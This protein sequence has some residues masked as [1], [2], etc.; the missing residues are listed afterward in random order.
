MKA[1]EAFEEGRRTPLVEEAVALADALK[2]RLAVLL[3]L[4]ADPPRVVEDT[5]VTTLPPRVAHL[6]GDLEGEVQRL[7]RVCAQVREGEARWRRFAEAAVEGVVLH[8]RQ[9]VLDVNPQFAELFGY[10]EE[11]ALGRPLLAFV[12]ERSR[13]KVQ[14]V[15]ASGS[16]DPYEI[17]LVRKDGTIVR[18]V[19]RARVLRDGH[20]MASFRVARLTVL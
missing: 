12:T 3:G 10:N 5:D 8:D 14:E 4:E 19:V 11:E 2:I 15:L 6:I 18:V 9:V 16:I 17:E 7:E 13:A 1:L 20:R